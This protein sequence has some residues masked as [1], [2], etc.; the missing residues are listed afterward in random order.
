MTRSLFSIERQRGGGA[1]SGRLRTISRLLWWPGVG[2][3]AGVLTAGCASVRPP[4]LDLRDAAIVLRADDPNP[5][6]G[7][8][9]GLLFEND[10]ADI[11]GLVGLSVGLSVVGACVLAGPLALPCVA[12]VVPASTAVGAAGGAALNGV[13]DDRVEA[14]RNA[15]G[16]E[17]AKM[18]P[19][20]ILAE[21]VQRK[22]REMFQ[23]ELP[24][25]AETAAVDSIEQQWL[26]GLA[27]TDV[28]LRKQGVILYA[29]KPVL[30]LQV[31]G[32]ITLRRA[33]D[34]QLV[35]QIVLV[36]YDTGKALTMPEWE[37]VGG[38]ML[39]VRLDQQLDVLSEL[40][41]VDI[42]RTAAAI[43]RRRTGP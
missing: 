28:S 24:L 14:S 5:S 7:R 13:R 26:I 34:P 20:E 30:Q 35:Y 32:R 3:L 29:L 21:R 43:A 16:A 17:L 15:V 25:L 27:L 19:T 31:A 40:M 18:S 37:A 2:L 4:E 23:I 22:A 42:Q 38:A 10:G 33:A 9:S 8:N 1:R 36:T 6:I 12:V 11:G 41:L 39:R